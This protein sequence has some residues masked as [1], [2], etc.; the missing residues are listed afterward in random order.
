MSKKYGFGVKLAVAAVAVAG[1]AI[2]AW[3][4]L[5]GTSTGQTGTMAVGFPVQNIAA[6]ECTAKDPDK[7]TLLE[8]NAESDATGQNPGTLG[9]IKV[10]TNSN[11]WDIWMTTAN[12]GR[13]RYNAGG[14][15]SATCAAP[16]PWDA[17]KC[18]TPGPTLTVGG[19]DEFL[20][21]IDAARGSGTGPGI[22]HDGVAASATHIPK[23][24]VQ[25]Q[26]AIG[27]AYLGS[28]L[29]ASANANT[30]YGLGAPGS[31]TDAALV[32]NTA[33]ETSGASYGS[34]P[35]TSPTPLAALPIKFAPLLGAH[36]GSIAA[37]SGTDYEKLAGRGWD[38]SAVGTQYVKTDG[39][40]A[41]AHKDLAS[42][43]NPKHVDEQYFFVNVGI[44]PSE[45]DA[46]GGNVNGTYTETFTFDLIAN[47]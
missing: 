34:R 43:T 45:K 32:P 31:Y 21:Y 47:F 38:G 18:K 20:T 46:I 23:D 27:V 5:P 11:G 10:T 39:F 40:A 36:Y 2:V 1:V 26:V 14:R 30:I 4:G 37:L 19:V 8:T 33:L 35:A 29:N 15:D 6:I 7:E 22:I 3:A 16:D 28:Q 24:T 25:L 44:L 41:P 42:P 13:L 12:G 9:T 17:S